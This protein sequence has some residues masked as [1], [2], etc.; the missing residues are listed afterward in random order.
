M[1]RNVNYRAKGLSVFVEF[2]MP[3]SGNNLIDKVIRIIRANMDN[4]DFG[5]EKLSREIGMSRVHL[6]RKLKEIMNISP[7]NLFD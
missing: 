3:G 1:H 6:N 4:P 7:S 2:D 5:V